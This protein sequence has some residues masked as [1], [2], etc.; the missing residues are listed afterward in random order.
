MN[1]L[2]LNLLQRFPELLHATPSFGVKIAPMKFKEP[3]VLSCDLLGKDAVIRDD[4]G[5]LH[6]DPCASDIMLRTK[7][8]SYKFIGR[9]KK[10]VIEPHFYAAGLWTTG[11]WHLLVD[12]IPMVIGHAANLPIVVSSRFGDKEEQIMRFFGI[13]NTIVKIDQTTHF[14]RLKVVPLGV[15]P[16]EKRVEALQSNVGAFHGAL[17]SARKI[18][19]SRADAS[20]R[21]IVNEHDLTAMLSRK[22][23]KEV[24][25]GTLPLR[26][27][28]AIINKA[29]TIVMPHGAAGANLFA[30]RKGTTVIEILP[31]IGWGASTLMM[32]QAC[33]LGYQFFPAIN[34]GMDIRVD[35][36]E[37]ELVV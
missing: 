18:Y 8:L 4:D 33:G 21:R 22:G 17:P 19:I 2:L 15:M 28:L 14:D 1:N 7:A 5:C 20:R 6:A 10:R 35:V 37:L 30:A 26:Q 25:L 31:S 16:F 36:N 29:E 27:Q 24:V 3:S 13:K 11:H 12:V 23:F 9:A 32:C 34:W